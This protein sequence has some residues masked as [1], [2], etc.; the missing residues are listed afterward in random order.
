MSNPLSFDPADMPEIEARSN[1]ICE[2]WNAGHRDRAVA[3]VRDADPWV[4]KHLRIRSSVDPELKLIVDQEQYR[5]A[6]DA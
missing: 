4:L 6:L 2:A 3:L 1:L 5:R